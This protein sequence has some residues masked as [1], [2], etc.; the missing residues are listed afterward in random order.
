[1]NRR[2]RHKQTEPLVAY[3]KERSPRPSLK[4]AENALFSGIG[5]YHHGQIGTI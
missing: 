3:E 5:D 2:I 4:S 1:M